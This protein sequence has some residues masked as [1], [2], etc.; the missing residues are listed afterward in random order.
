MAVSVTN[1]QGDAGL[2]FGG[3]PQIP[4]GAEND[5]GVINRTGELL[6]MNNLQQN[7]TLY[8]QKLKERDQ[9][10]SALDSGDIKV[11]DLLEQDTPFVKEG[12]DALDQAWEERMRK[13]VNDIDAQRN[14][15]KALRDV[16]D[17]VTQAQARKLFFDTENAALS[18]ETLPRKQTARK[19]NLDK[20]LGSGFFSDLTPF[21][22]AQ[23]LDIQGSIL[24]T[25]QNITEQFTDPKDPLIKGKRTVFDYDKTLA[26]NQD[27]FLNDANKAYD[28]EQLMNSITSLPPKDFVENMTAMNNRIM[29]YN[30]TRGL[31]P[32]DN[33]Y[34]SEIEFTVNPQTGKAMIKERL[35]DFAAKY[36]LT[37]QKPFG[38]VQ[39]EFD[40]DRASFMLGQE[41]NRIS[42]ANAAA[43]QMRA[44][45]Y[46]DIQRKKLADLTNDEKK[47]KNIWGGLVK[48]VKE[49]PRVD[50]LKTDIVM[51]GDIPAGYKNI[52]GLNPDGKPIELRPKK[53]GRD[54]KLLYY[55]T[56]YKGLDG[57]DINKDFLV[58][59]YN[60]YKGAGGSG[61]YNS[62]VRRLINEGVIDMELVGEN[63][64]ANFET[65]FQ[66][67]RALSN[68]LGSGKE[69]PVFSESETIIED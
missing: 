24:S 33:G 25:A 6:L 19:G 18:K 3:N 12:L 50:G 7:K 55:Q 68:K 36:T 46:V 30:A 23:D 45:A 31:K 41:R 53:G 69:E 35:P 1:Y 38:S 56:K 15:T 67:A 27:N 13:G 49:T 63:G 59:K 17:R 29:E 44:K 65:A 61:D 11:G 8:E 60:S 5:L 62:Y 48:N 34:V 26:A 43:N 10:L 39:T 21:Q 57:S 51:I 58:D 9:L 42:A 20:V 52:A 16:Q 37:R 66:M 28:Q 47:V 54:G 2:G 64:T 14:Y 32:G 4:V 22:Q 40:K